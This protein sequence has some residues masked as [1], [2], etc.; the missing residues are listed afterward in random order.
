MLCHSC[1]LEK[2]NHPFDKAA[3][4]TRLQNL[5]SMTDEEVLAK[6]RELRIQNDSSKDGILES[7]LGTEVELKDKICEYCGTTY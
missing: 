3:E 1:N 4:E 7:I 5:Y 6:R 2:T